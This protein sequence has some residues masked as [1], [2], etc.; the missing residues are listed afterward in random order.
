MKQL[1]LLNEPSVKIALITLGIVAITFYGC[2]NFITTPH[3]KKMY[4]LEAELK[5][6]KLENQIAKQKQ[7]VDSSE[8]TLSPQKEPT[9]LLS[10]ITHIAQKSNLDI[11]SLEPLAHRRIEPYT[12]VSFKITST[13]TYS[14]I[15]DFIKFT[16]KSNYL[17]ILDKLDIKSSEEYKLFLSQKELSE[18]DSPDITAELV[19]GTVY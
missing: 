4:V 10:E 3:K 14:E 8:K 5:R 15:M 2:K 13:C 1:S 9:W 11:T 12:Y 16:E 17:I 19:V 7:K 18:K 6:T